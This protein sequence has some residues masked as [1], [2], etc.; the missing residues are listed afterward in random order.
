MRK[1]K[2]PGLK[3]VDLVT[4]EIGDKIK[5]DSF[6]VT[7]LKPH[8]GDNVKI[9]FSVSNVTKSIIKLVPWRIV[10]GKTIVYSGYRFN[11]LPLS[12]F[13]VTVTWEAVKGKH[14][15]FV[16][17]DPQNILDEPRSKQFDNFPQGVDVNVQ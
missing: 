7:P 3:L 2:L 6:I 13:D 5:V 15:F 1:S 10:N 8:N 16:D 4:N 17:I 14:F 12:S 11:L 9:K